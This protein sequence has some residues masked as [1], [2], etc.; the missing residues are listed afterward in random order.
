MTQ[1]A[2]PSVQNKGSKTFSLGGGDGVETDPVCTSK[3]P[4]PPPRP[5]G[6]TGTITN[7]QTWGGCQQGAQPRTAE[8][9]Q[10]KLGKLTLIE[11]ARFAK[12]QNYGP[13]PK[14]RKALPLWT[15]R[16]SSQLQ[17]QLVSWVGRNVWLRENKAGQAGCWLVKP[18]RRPGDLLA[19]Q[20]R[21]SRQHQETP[22]RL[23]KA[24][25]HTV[26]KMPKNSQSSFRGF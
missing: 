8:Y 13:N 16:P 1:G 23:E 25:S 3:K 5:Q 6:P 18:L 12:G 19:Q 4:L 26:W 22:G 9:G 2:G 17:R 10:M 7:T 21:L 14:T 15:R 20:P 11:L 24:A